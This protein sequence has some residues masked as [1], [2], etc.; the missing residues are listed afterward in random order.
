MTWLA[1]VSTASVVISGERAAALLGVTLERF[2]SGQVFIVAPI[3]QVPGQLRLDRIA[4]DLTAEQ[5]AGLQA[6]SDA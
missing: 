1:G 5:F 4:V 2:S 3:G 6:R